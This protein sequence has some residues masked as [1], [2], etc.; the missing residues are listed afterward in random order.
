MTLRLASARYSD[1]SLYEDNVQVIE[2]WID[3]KGPFSRRINLKD[4]ASNFSQPWN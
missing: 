2:K 4:L 1:L 3:K